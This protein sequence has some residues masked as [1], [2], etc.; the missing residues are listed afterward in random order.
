MS[1]SRTPLYVAGAAIAASIVAWRCAPRSPEKVNAGGI[2]RPD[3][4]AAAPS[5]RPVRVPAAV[6]NT[7]TS[8]ASTGGPRVVFFSPWGGSTTAQLGRDRPL[9]GNPT[10]PMSLARDAQGRLYVL[11]QVNG[12]IVRHGADGKPDA[13]R[14]VRLRAAQ[15]IAIG[16]DGSMA[17][18]DRLGDKAIALYGDDGSLRGQ[19]PLGGELVEETGLV[20]GVFVD[21]KDVYVEREHGPLVRIGDTAGGPAEPRTEIPGRPSRDG[22]SYINAGIA[23]AAA[24]RAYVASIERATGDHRFTRELRLKSEIRSIQLLDTDLSGTI[25]LAVELHDDKAGEWISLQ[26]LEPLKGVPIGSAV[27]PANTL[28][29]ETFRDFTVLDDGGVVFAHRSEAGVSYEF[30]D[31]N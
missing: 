23:E 5:H 30:Y 9:E 26:C 1:N 16:A 27:L 11:D 13:T 31:C 22:L 17:V 20:T 2:R 6:A 18:L 3:T 10:G 4:E 25:Y 12:R 14:D 15:D 29:E 7:P 19:L 21:G 28:P 24:G 8:D